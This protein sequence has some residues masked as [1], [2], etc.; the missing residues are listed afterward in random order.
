[1]HK[2]VD[3]THRE[4]RCQWP[5]LRAAHPNP[6]NPLVI[7]HGEMHRI[8]RN[9]AYRTCH[10]IIVDLLTAEM[11]SQSRM[12]DNGAITTHEGAKNSQPAQAKPGLDQG[13]ISHE[14]PFRK[15]SSDPVE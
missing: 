1:M 15:T 2:V 3:K 11:C 5:E 9:V 13:Q 4:I 14:S 12:A 10:D 7:S 6:E 8:P